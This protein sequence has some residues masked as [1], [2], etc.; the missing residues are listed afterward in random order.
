[1]CGAAQQQHLDLPLLSLGCPAA[2][3][4]LLPTAHPYC[5]ASLYPAAVH[6]YSITKQL[7]CAIPTYADR[8]GLQSAGK[9]QEDLQPNS[10]GG[11]MLL[12]PGHEG[13]PSQEWR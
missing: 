13:A 9:A 5:L 1:M 11:R 2:S 10:K 12:R 4:M 8:L 3:W 6:S 7:I